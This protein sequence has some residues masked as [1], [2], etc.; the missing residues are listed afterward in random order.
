MP[1]RPRPDSSDAVNLTSPSPLPDVPCVTSIHDALLT[2]VHGQ[3]GA[4]DT[5]TV[6]PPPVAVTLA[7]DGVIE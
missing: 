2:A 4:V 3:P 1:V 7:L 6:P 5:V